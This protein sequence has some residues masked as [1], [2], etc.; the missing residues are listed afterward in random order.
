MFKR[1]SLTYDALY[2][3]LA[4][5][6]DKCKVSG[7]VCGEMAEEISPGGGVSRK[8]GVAEL[9]NLRVQRDARHQHPAR[10]AQ[11]LAGQERR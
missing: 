4:S 6:L 3:L 8:H 2:D 7:D 10:L 1:N 5:T 9:A 11:H